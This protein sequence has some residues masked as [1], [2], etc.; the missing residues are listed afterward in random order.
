MYSRALGH[1]N[2]ESS[3]IAWLWKRLKNKTTT[4]G[5][6]F[7]KAH[8]EAKLYRLKYTHIVAKVCSFLKGEQLKKKFR[9]VGK[10]DEGH[11]CGF[12]GIVN[13][14]DFSLVMVPQVLLFT[15]VTSFL[16]IKYYILIFFSI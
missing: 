14:T 5:H 6:Y 7:Y 10:W 8:K 4:V 15:Y 2:P 12:E 11:T 13:V 16:Y 1:G 9:M 3:P